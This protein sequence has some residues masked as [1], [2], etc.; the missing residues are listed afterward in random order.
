MRRRDFLAMTGASLVPFATPQTA[1]GGSEFPV[2]YRRA[3]PYEPLLRYA[4]P[5]SDEFKSEKHAVELERRLEQM[6]RGKEP[7]PT[8]LHHWTGRLREIRSARFHVL[9]EELV[10]YE[11]TTPGEYHTGLWHLPDFSTVAEQTASS[12]NPLFRDVTSHVFGNAQSFR[13]Q[14]LN[15]NPWWRARIDS[16]AGIDVYGNQG[17][18][19]GDIDN[20]GIDEVYIC[21]PGG[22]PNR[23]YKFRNDG[24]AEDITDRAGLAILDETTSALFLD[25]R[26]S[27]HQDLV[28]LRSSGPLLFLNQGNGT[29]REHPGAF[30]F[31]TSPQGS[32]TGMAA[33]DYDRDGRL[34]L[35]LCCYVYFQSEDQYQYPAPYHDARNG[36]PNFMF[37]NRLT[38]TAGS[39]DDV[40][41][42]V[43]LNENNNRFSFAPA[44]CDFDGDGWPDLYV[45]NDFGRNNLYR[46]LGGRFRDEAAKAGVEDMGPGMSA[47]WF[48]YD[49]DGRPDLYVSNMWTAAGQRV[50][51]DPA[52]KPA[53]NQ[54][55]AY[56]R[57]TK[58]NSLY[59]NR[60][61]GTFEETGAAQQ[62]EMGRWAWTSGG[63]D[64]DHDGEPEIFI[65]TG[66]VS[67]PGDVKADLDSFFWRQVV[68]RS[69]SSPAPAPAYEN[70]WSAINQMIRGDHGWNAL[71]PNVFYIRRSGKYQD[72]SGVS[73]LDF[74]DDSRA[75][76]VTDFD[77]DGNL[78]IVLKSRLGPQVRVLQNNCGTGKPAIAISLHGTKSNRDAIG[79]RVEVNGRAQWV[80]A[81][82]GFL[83]QHTKR[84]LFG[85]GSAQRADVVVTWP[86]GLLQRFSNLR[87]GFRYD[88]T[89]GSTSPVPT[90]FR[91]RTEYRDAPM[92]PVNAPERADTWLL[93]PIPTPDKRRG[94]GFLVLHDG[95][96]VAIQASSSVAV[97]DL[98]REPEEVAGAY[99]LLCRYAL[100]YRGPF[101]L[102]L[103]LLLDRDGH[104]RKLYPRVPA[105]DVMRGDL[106]RMDEHRTLALPFPGRYYAEPHRNYFKLGAALYWAGYPD[107]ALPY[108]EKTV[109]SRPDNWK[110]LLAI[111]RIQQ[112]TG[113]FAESLATFQRL[114]AVRPDYVP[115]MVSAADA[116]NKTGDSKSAEK[117]LTKAMAVD[118]N[119]ADAANELGL[120]AAN[121]D[122][123]AAAR[124]WFQRAISAKRDHSSAINNLGVLYAKLGQTND[125][126][127][128]FQY[129]IDVSPDDETLYLNLGRLYVTAGKTQQAREVIT[130][131]L[132]RKPGS[133]IGT[134]ALADLEG[135]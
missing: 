25:L 73:G 53:E 129:G 122:D 43:G 115:A 126:I 8:A 34:D 84:L 67:S 110:A 119:C 105:P 58:G 78:D 96:A 21:Q 69:P 5:G 33:A 38:D 116:Y 27:G 28:A 35:Y 17:I 32:F 81:G 90:P 87:P 112:E 19:V 131:L 111:G 64:F 61:D 128:A 127:A 94:P 71:E 54:R 134:K 22:L 82:S 88:I 93:E 15:G 74:A 40:T 121:R 26:N 130:R 86:S 85:L 95:S 57:H 51:R 132:D 120:I 98:T 42:E 59:R 107:R 103:T 123:Y 76:A 7:I 24:T 41:E 36:P 108:L 46:N 118:P 12:R 30:R 83:S 52:F 91:S 39:F 113:H 68:A 48:D 2:H 9:P 92:A 13:E 72:Y 49:G 37:R 55:D 3:N 18:A 135:R 125:A 31:R 47:S 117:M 106:A 97:V 45:A 20:D 75:F 66:M 11:I 65:A 102:P 89:E 133:A 79:A 1:R 4:E 60:G 99:A 6:F 124:Q 23:L 56:R 44:W 50:T 104:V 70:G 16:A 62:V 77:G 100:E 29:F 14:L 114:L 63:F 10:R 80:E 109:R 101:Q